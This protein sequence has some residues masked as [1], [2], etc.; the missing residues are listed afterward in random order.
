MMNYYELLYQGLY[1]ELV[2]Q[3]FP[4]LEQD[5]D[6][7]RAFLRLFQSRNAIFL[8]DDYESVNFLE[9]EAEKGN[10]YA[11]YAYGRWQSIVRGGEN[12][13]WIAYRNMKAAADQGLPDAIAG[14]SLVYDY[15]DIGSVD[16][17]KSD[18]LM[19]Q[20]IAMGSE[21]GLKMKIQCL[22][23]GY[24]YKDAKPAEAEAMTD[25]LIRE[26]EEK[27]IEPNG[28]WFYYRASAREGRMGRAL[29]VLEDYR[30][31]LKL[32]VLNAYTDLIIAAGYTEAD[33]VLVE[34]KEYNDLIIEG[35]AHR[36]SGAFY[37]DAAREMRRYD[38]L[39]EHYVDRGIEDE[40]IP[41][42][43]LCASHDLIHSR[44]SHAAELGD[45]AAWELIGDF[46]YR[47]DY[48]FEKDY[49]KAF[50][51][52]SNGVIHDSP[53]SAESLWKMMHD[54]LIDRPLDYQD[55]I[56]IMGARWGSKRLLAETVIAGQEGRLKEY[57]DEI[58]KYFAPIFD[59]PEFSLDSDEDWMQVIDEQ[60]GD[61]DDDF[62]E[63]DGRYDAWA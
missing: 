5:K 42:N 46:Y 12:S 63:D 51:C 16:W 26:Y 41:Y 39:R 61:D 8:L 56:A 58:E 3:A 55:S 20:A 11:Q 38:A 52:Y 18:E 30:R 9:E 57:A 23:F 33:S 6:A 28:D 48:G 54:K 50:V 49:Q 59:A 43:V 34:T 13:L 31:A 22:C 35:M 17:E 37:L 10:K 36:A 47:G 14:M 1:D 29:T 27:G 60:L 40:K 15:G 21:L 45:K 4:V 62:E 7:E 19:E 25:R 32:G 44:L 53:A 2:K 24:H